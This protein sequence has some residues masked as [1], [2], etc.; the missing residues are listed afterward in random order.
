MYGVDGDVHHD[1][2]KE[3][4]EP[5][6]CYYNWVRAESKQTDWNAGANE[7]SETIEKPEAL[8]AKD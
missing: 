7:A 8:T 2:T 1:D 6:S 3:P 5:G 4:R